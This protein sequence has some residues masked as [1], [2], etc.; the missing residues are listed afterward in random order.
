M[1]VFPFV[2]VSLI[3]MADTAVIS[4]H[5]NRAR[6]LYCPV[7][8]DGR[9]RSTFL[10]SVIATNDGPPSPYAKRKDDIPHAH[11]CGGMVNHAAENKKTF[12]LLDA[13]AGLRVSKAQ[14]QVVA[15][16]LR[17]RSHRREIVGNSGEVGDSMLQ[18]PEWQRGRPGLQQPRAKVIPVP[19][20]FKKLLRA[21]P[22]LLIDQYEEDTQTA[23]ST[24]ECRSELI[25][26]STGGDD[27]IEDWEGAYH[28]MQVA[29]Y[30]VRD[31]VDPKNGF[32]ASLVS[33]I[34]P[35]N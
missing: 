21:S 26:K 20:N 32:S 29:C 4:D 35:T 15:E 7:S 14:G 33:Q 13:L 30:G 9:S 11:S 12:A 3:V 10:A 18:R 19:T 25:A 24:L 1:I 34:D 16:A 22:H 23:F 2:N 28:T 8:P 5:R 6:L 27:V 31:W 17:L